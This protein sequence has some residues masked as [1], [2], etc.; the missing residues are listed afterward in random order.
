[1]NSRCTWQHREGHA[2][3]LQHRHPSP[4][5]FLAEHAL[6]HQRIDIPTVS[7]NVISLMASSCGYYRGHFEHRAAHEFAVHVATQRG[8]AKRLQHRHA[9]RAQPVAPM[10]ERHC[11]CPRLPPR[12]GTAQAP[13][14][15]QGH[16]GGPTQEEKRP[17][18][19]TLPHDAM[20][21]RLSSFRLL[22][23]ASPPLDARKYSIIPSC[24]SDALVQFHG[25]VFAF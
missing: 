14:R 24:P 15:E 12:R 6:N 5:C 9:P 23:M 20:P 22:A 16:P 21:T 8:L 11:R 25:N 13:R 10:R 19:L 4:P 3:R 17:N 7:L 1:M 2:K 18:R